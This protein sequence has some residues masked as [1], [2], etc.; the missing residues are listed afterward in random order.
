MKKQ[1]YLER[2]KSGV[3]YYRRPIKAELQKIL[4]KTQFKQS[5]KTRDFSVA[6]Q[7]AL[8]IEREHSLLFEQVI[9][10]NADPSDTRVLT[11]KEL[12]LLAMQW[13]K[14]LEDGKAQLD[15]D[16][17]L[18]LKKD[19]ALQIEHEDLCSLVACSITNHF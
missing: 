8:H 9:R 2:H 12:T 19:D 7:N 15:K 13:L 18:T 10:R 16:L 5:L 17:R 3:W 4:K 1:E 11:E 6:K 14:D